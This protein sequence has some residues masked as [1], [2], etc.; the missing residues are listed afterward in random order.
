MPKKEVKMTYAVIDSLRAYASF[1]RL[2]RAALYLVGTQLDHTKIAHGHE[3]FM[4]L[5]RSTDGG[6]SADELNE[7]LVEAGL[8]EVDDLHELLTK[9]DSDGS[10]EVDYGEFI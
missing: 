3:L 4:G 6:L 2:K 10:G 5:D 1:P 7:A 9:V 8:N